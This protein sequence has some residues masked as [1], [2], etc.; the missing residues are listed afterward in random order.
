VEG[1][2]IELPLHWNQWVVDPSLHTRSRAVFHYMGAPKPW[3][4]DYNGRFSDLFLD[5]LDRTP[6]RG[7]RPWNPGGL[8]AL[9]ARTR[10]RVP[11]LPAVIRIARRR[12]G[13]TP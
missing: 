7:T 13:R 4:A 6:F 11:Y 8:G 9:L 1:D 10:R 3:H 2:W 12:L 5:C